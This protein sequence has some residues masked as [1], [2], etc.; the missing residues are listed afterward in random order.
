MMKYPAQNN[1]IKDGVILDH[2]LRIQSTVKRKLWWQER[3]VAG[4]TVFTVK[5]QEELDAAD[6]F[7]FPF[8][9]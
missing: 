7:P 1:V 2:T 3:K 5:E 9:M 8:L 6:K 4:H